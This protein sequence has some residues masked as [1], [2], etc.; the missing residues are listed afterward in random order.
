VNE[1]GN[2]LDK[3]F[4]HDMAEAE[5]VRGTERS[6]SSLSVDD[7][8][9]K[10]RQ[11]VMDLPPGDLFTAD[12]LVEFVGLPTESDLFARCNNAVGGLLAGLSRKDFIRTAGITTSD[13]VSNHGRILRVWERV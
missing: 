3:V 7:W 6:L 8:K 11:W 4:D 13:R 10:A 9:I 2:L 5:K 1:Q 12:T